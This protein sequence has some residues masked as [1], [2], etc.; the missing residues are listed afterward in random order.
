MPQGFK[1]RR[2]V[3]PAQRLKKTLPLHKRYPNTY[4]MRG[5]VWSPNASSSLEFEGPL[6][7]EVA[8]LIMM[9]WATGEYKKSELRLMKQLTDSLVVPDAQRPR[10]KAKT[11]G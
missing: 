2:S 8:R 11:D 1:G 10:K 6:R 7:D 3:A 4:I 9:L 5:K